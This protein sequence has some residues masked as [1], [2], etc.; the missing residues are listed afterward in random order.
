[1]R[2]FLVVG[3]LAALAACSRAPAA[4]PTDA[5]PTLEGKSVSLSSCPTEKCLTVQ[6]APW[7]HYCRAATPLLLKLRPYLAERGVTMRFVVGLDKM[8][9]LRDYAA[10]FGP[11]TALDAK[12]AVGGSGVPHFMVSDRQGRVI[13]DVPGMPQLDTVEDVAAYFGLP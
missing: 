4:L 13:K 5:L 6:V 7:C 10:V 9:A 11:D 2:R 1:V 12:G 3:L 8:A